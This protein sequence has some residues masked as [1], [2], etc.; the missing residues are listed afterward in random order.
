M[1]GDLADRRRALERVEAVDAVHVHVDES[2][3]D[4]V[5]PTDRTAARRILPARDVVRLIADP[6]VFDDEGAAARHA[7]G[8][9]QVGA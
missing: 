4:V 1:P 8:Q 9:H 5:I 2:R 6:I 3:N 7:I